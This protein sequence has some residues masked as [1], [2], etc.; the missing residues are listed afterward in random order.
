MFIKYIPSPDYDDG[1]WWVCSNN[2]ELVG[3]SR[4]EDAQAAID[5]YD[6]YRSEGQSHIVSKQY[7]GLL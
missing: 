3:F 4:L 2:E 7:A 1:L 6:D 5:T